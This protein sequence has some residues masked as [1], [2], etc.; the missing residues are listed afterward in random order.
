MLES[1]PRNAH[2]AHGCGSGHRALHDVPHGDSDDPK[3]EQTH[4]ST[5]NH[6]SYGAV[7]KGHTY[8]KEAD[9]VI[10]SVAQEIESVGLEGRGT[11]SQA[12][13]DLHHEHGHIDGEHGPQG[14]PI[15]RVTTMNVGTLMLAAGGAHTE[16]SLSPG[17]SP[18]ISE[19]HGLG[20]KLKWRAHPRSLSCDSS[21]GFFA[22][23]SAP[24]RA[25]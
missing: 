3:A 1:P 17:V 19:V 8:D 18:H 23:N 2:N 10:S 25:F 16:F 4:G 6:G 11:R 12:G 9:N 20:G 14:T 24:F 7:P 22:G 5:F 13:D 21:R 15:V